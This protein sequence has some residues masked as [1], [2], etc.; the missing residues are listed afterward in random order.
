MNSFNKY[1]FIFLS[2]FWS[3][4]LFGQNRSSKIDTPATSHSVEK[5]RLSGHVRYFFMAT[6]NE[7]PLTDYHAHALSVI[8]KYETIKWKGFSLTGGAAVT[9]NL[10]SSDLEKVDPT[11][12][13][14]NR[15]EAG[16]F[17]LRNPNKFAGIR[18]EVLYLQYTLPKGFVR[19]GS[20]P[21][22]TPFINPQDGRLRPTFASGIYAKRRTST[23]Q[24]EAGWIGSMLP[25]SINGW[26]GVAAS[27]GLNPQGVHT[28]GSPANYAGQ[29]HSKGVFMVGISHTVSP[30]IKI[31]LWEQFV[32]NL[33]NTA[34]LQVEAEKPLTEKVKHLAAL[35][36]V[37][38]V[39]VADGGKNE[40]TKGYFQSAVPAQ[41]ISAMTGIKSDRFEAS[42]NYTRITSKARYLSPREWGREPFFTFMPRERTEGFGDVK[43]FVAKAAYNFPKAGLK[44]SVQVGHFRLPDVVNAELNKYGMPSY[45]QLNAELR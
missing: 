28:D 43:A 18:P 31:K 8:A 38:Q 40:K 26:H 22:N 2:L 11:T 34:L 23:T 37:H 21:I 41:V 1:G 27:I 29:L 36:Y 10:L 12:K 15:Y 33:F 6:D 9:I 5:G 24:L 7:Q 39:M 14:P 3:L 30:A 20:Q 42:L 17:D 35:Q 45:N 32:E 16:L 13:R 4:Q 44:T 19:V 25:R